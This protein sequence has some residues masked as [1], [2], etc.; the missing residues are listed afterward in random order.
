MTHIESRPGRGNTY[1]FYVDFEG[2]PSDLKIQ[3]LLKD[4]KSSCLSV[5][6]IGEKKVPWFPRR[7]GDLDLIANQVMKS[8]ILN[9][10]GWLI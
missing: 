3:G 8:K 5:M 2:N 10:I 4:L 9:N 7:K 6:T 1:S